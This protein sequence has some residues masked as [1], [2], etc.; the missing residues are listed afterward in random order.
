MA[1]TISYQFLAI[2][3]FSKVGAKVAGSFHKVERKINS[4][5][6]ATKNLAN[7]MDKISRAG[8][9]AFVGFALPLAG[10][11]AIAFKAQSELEQLQITF[12]SSLQSTEKA[13]AM[14][15]DL[16]N[17][18]KTTP[19]RMEG[20]VSTGRM[21]LGFGVTQEDLMERMTKLGDVA[22]GTG[23]PVGDL[24]MVFGQV[25]AKGRLLAE[26][27]NQFAERGLPLLEILAKGTGRTKKEILD[28]ASKGQ[29][30]FEMFQKAFDQMHELRYKDNMVKL[31]NSL[32]GLWS[33]LLDTFQLAAASFFERLDKLFDIKGKMK[34]MINVLNRASEGFNAFVDNNPKLAKMIFIVLGVIAA[35]SVLLTVLAP[36]GI[37]VGVVSLGLKML[38]GAFAILASP[39]V[40]IGAAVIGLIAALYVFQD[41]IKAWWK[42]LV[43]VMVAQK[44]KVVEA[45]CAPFK[46]A[47]AVVMS[48]FDQIKSVYESITDFLSISSDVNVKQSGIYTYQDMQTNALAGTPYGALSGA[49]LGANSRADV[50]V[51]LNAPKGTVGEVKTKTYGFSSA[52]VGTNLEEY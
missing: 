25:K 29:I 50:N 5:N 43:E 49:Q 31:S 26:E 19:F 51:N 13:K 15:E 4:A 6:R 18:A 9:A 42:S 16:I 32:G 11:T 22:A 44:D 36:L 10:F 3:K 45:I 30:S 20:V 27:I 12:E 28:F 21:L 39:F 52:N 23:R 40:L 46:A 7:S 33:T 38:A 37:I 35:V 8:Q 24:A 47:Y 2:D 41:E 34:S 1:F 17:F 14:V 48:V